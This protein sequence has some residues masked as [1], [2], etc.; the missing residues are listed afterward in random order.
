MDR[1]EWREIEPILDQALSMEEA[2]QRKA[3]LKYA[4]REDL[5]IYRKA[6]RLLNC[7]KEAEESGF[8][9]Y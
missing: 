1:E 9:E 6:K 4:C 2:Q 7:I 8:L 3:Y 5:N